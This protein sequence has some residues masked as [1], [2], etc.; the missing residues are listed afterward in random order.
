MAP[1]GG[2]IWEGVIFGG[3]LYLGGCYIWGVYGGGGG[4]DLPI[5][6]RGVRGT[7]S[8]TRHRTLG[9]GSHLDTTHCRTFSLKKY[10]PPPQ[11]R[12]LHLVLQDAL[13]QQRQRCA[14][15]RFLNPNKQE[16]FCKENINRFVFLSKS[17]SLVVEHPHK[18][19]LCL[20]SGVDAR[21]PAICTKHIV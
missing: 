5:K 7:P 16:K 13:Y 2:Y 10:L 12:S 15:C 17:H 19:F 6:G 4:P 8:S 18:H 11:K 1:Q 9:V 14:L 21:P 3:V 20:L